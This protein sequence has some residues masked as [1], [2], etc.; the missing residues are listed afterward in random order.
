[1]TIMERHAARMTGRGVCRILGRCALATI[2]ASLGAM[3]I[4]TFGADLATGYASAV[5]VTLRSAPVGPQSIAARPIH[6]PDA[7]PD[8]SAQR[9]RMV[10][11]LYEELMRRSLPGC[12]ST[13]NHGSSAGGC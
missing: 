8:R 9:A 1:M 3:S 5:A 2:G 13:S 4:S 12:S 7:K 10:D 6:P 11:Q